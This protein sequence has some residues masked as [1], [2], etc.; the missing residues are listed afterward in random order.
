MRTPQWKRY[1]LDGSDT[2]WIVLFQIL[3]LFDKGLVGFESTL[4]SGD[5]HHTH[6]RIDNTTL[7]SLSSSLS[8]LV[9]AIKREAQS[10]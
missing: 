10:R 7:C 5:R 1:D 6:S 3:I 2:R 4:G 9:T 8:Q